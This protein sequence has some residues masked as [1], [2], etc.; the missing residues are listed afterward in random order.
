M[1]QKKT[2]RKS[3]SG[4]TLTQEDRAQRGYRNRTFS[5]PDATS[6]AIDVLARQLGKTRSGVVVSAVAS[7]HNPEKV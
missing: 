1:G 2:P 3:P 4:S 5:I 6:D 7:L